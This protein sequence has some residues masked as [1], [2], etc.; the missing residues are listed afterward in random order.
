MKAA[1]LLAPALA[2]ALA[3]PVPEAQEFDENVRPVAGNL[4]I[5]LP[6]RGNELTAL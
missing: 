4:F 1:L 2:S 5:C 6:I 3:V